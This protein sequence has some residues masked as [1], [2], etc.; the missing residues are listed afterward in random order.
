M[1][2]DADED[3]YTYVLPA[4]KEY[5]PALTRDHSVSLATIVATCGKLNVKDDA[6]WQLFEKKLITDRLYR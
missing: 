2:L 4:L 6:L 3:F 1:N 5:V